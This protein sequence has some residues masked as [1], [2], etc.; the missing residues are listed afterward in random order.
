MN[1]LAKDRNGDACRNKQMFTD[2]RFCRIHQYMN[3]Y[4]DEMLHKGEPKIADVAYV[5][6]G[7]I[8]AIFEILHT[9]KTSDDARPEP[10]FEIEANAVLDLDP[11]PNTT[12]IILPCVRKI[13]LETCKPTKCPGCFQHEPCWLIEINHGFCRN[14]ATK[15][16]SRGL[17]AQKRKR[18]LEDDALP[19]PKAIIMEGRRL[20]LAEQMQVSSIETRSFIY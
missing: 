20:F 7:K 11:G 19:N 13:F 18:D 16:H 15:C 4:T 9:H 14:C 5:D 1:C 6:N 3:H 10:W 17:E 12:E 2:T 8:V